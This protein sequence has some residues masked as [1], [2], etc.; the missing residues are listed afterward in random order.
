[1]AGGPKPD[2]RLAALNKETG[3]TGQVGVAW[4]K[5]GGSI[6]IKLNAFTHLVADKDLVLTLFPTN[7]RDKDWWEKNKDRKEGG[8]PF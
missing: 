7:D 6:S 8:P 1:M 5:E 3:L 2:W 4:N